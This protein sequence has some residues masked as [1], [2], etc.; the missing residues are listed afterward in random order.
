[1]YHDGEPNAMERDQHETTPPVEPL[2]NEAREQHREEVRAFAD[3]I[4][5]LLDSVIQ[6]PG[7][8]VRIG[9]DPLL[10]LIPGLGDVI[11]ALIGSTI[12]VLAA[13][14]QIPKI[15]MVRMAMNVGINAMVGIIPGIG[16]LFSI[17]FRSNLRNAELLRHHAARRTTRATSWDWL[18][19]IGFIVGTLALTVG[20][21][22]L[23]IMGLR[24][25]WH[26][27]TF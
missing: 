7:T 13:E 15:V 20:T 22:T 1:M 16:D 4:A 27:D 18:V 19:V 25:L 14:L 26:A 24:T 3:R 11:A 17:W 5:T 12:L 6:I 2:P 10:G 9:I 21:F 23:I 8:S